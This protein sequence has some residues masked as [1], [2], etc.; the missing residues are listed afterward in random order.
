MRHIYLF[1]LVLLF[2]GCSNNGNIKRAL[3][4]AEAL[5][6]SDPN[7]AQSVIDSIHDSRIR[8]PQDEARYNLLR[9]YCDYRLYQEGTNDSLIRQAESYFQKEGTSYQKMLSLFLHAQILKNSKSY[10]ESMLCF[11]K[12]LI[13][14]EQINDHFMLGQIYSQMYQLCGPTL[15]CEQVK[16][17]QKALSEYK[18]HQDS[19]YI[20]DGE[21]NLAI[22]LF[23]HYRYDE[24][25]PRF[26]AAIDQAT[27][28]ND[29]FAL[30][31]SLVF[32]AESELMTDSYDQVLSHLN[33][34][35]EIDPTTFQNRGN[36][37]MALYYAKK[38]LKDKAIYHLNIASKD[39]DTSS[40]MGNYLHF[41]SLVYAALEDYK[42]AL[43]YSD[44]YH[45]QLDSIY[46]FSI[47]NSVMKAQKD[48]SDQKWK[49]FERASQRYY[50]VMLILGFLIVLA[51][52]SFISYRK[53]QKTRI[54]LHEERMNRELVQ[55]EMQQKQLQFQQERLRL[56]EENRK[57]ALQCIKQTEPVLRLRKALIGKYSLHEEDWKDI[58]DIFNDLIPSFEQQLRAMH[59]IND[60]EWRIC[61]LVKL[62]FSPADIAI[63]TNK[64]KA[65]ISAIRTRLYF[66][67]FQEE[68]TSKKL[69]DFL[70]SI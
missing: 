24:C 68:G 60:S 51:V 23:C 59:P 29:T 48:F 20:L 26:Q 49:E 42:Q 25:I 21:I 65:S 5:V 16:Y 32:L 46:S 27:Q 45:R 33:Q 43:H 38:G 13:E 18:L 7:A 17:A 39:T 8:N 50:Y 19:V 4:R 15:D 58:Y 28:K 56:K 6:K 47:N 9:T 64:T 2:A 62:E 22:A 57:T 67:L 37:L 40:N 66:K 69:D 31:K 41:S 54:L 63:L 55:L 61:Q 36:S 44:L 11:K 34:A 14:A 3:N 35:K 30:V 10:L 1:I 52:I 70:M 12:S 53:Q